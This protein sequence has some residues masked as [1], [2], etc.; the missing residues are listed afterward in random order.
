MHLNRIKLLNF[1]KRSVAAV[2]AVSGFFCVFISAHSFAQR[3][4]GEAADRY[5]TID[6]EEGGRRIANFRNQRLEGDYCFHFELEHLPRRGERVT[7]Y[8]TM[9]GSWNEQGPVTRIQLLSN[10]QNPE[11]GAKS[12]AIELII[13]NGPVPRAWSRLDANADFKLL[14]GDALYES[15]LPNVTYSA[16]DLQMPF[17]YWDEYVYEGPG[18]VQSR[19]AQQF[20]M[21][22]PAGSVARQRGIDAVRIGLDDAYDALLRIEV[23]DEQQEELSRFTVESFKKIQGQ[24]IVKEVTLKDYTTRD[25]TRFKVKAASVGLV[26][27]HNVF[28][29]C[30][31]VEPLEIP[32]QMFQVL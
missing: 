25:R 15:V 12:V 21:Q 3:A 8:G 27:E 4:G 9:W 1:K 13:Q 2:C 20:L 19:I 32:Q 6:P 28:N 7:Y 26:L 5:K 17:V 22:A 30:H 23:L 14:R 24:Y 18:R 11:G 29:P 10:N 31:A 16:F